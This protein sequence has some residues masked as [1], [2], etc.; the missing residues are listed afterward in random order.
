[1]TETTKQEGIVGLFDVITFFGA[2]PAIALYL[3]TGNKVIQ[4]IAMFFVILILVI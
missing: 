2:L 4:K 1:M 3:L